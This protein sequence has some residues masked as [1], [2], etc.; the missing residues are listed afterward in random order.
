MTID[1]AQ[2]TLAPTWRAVEYLR[3]STDYQQIS[4]STQQDRIR[5]YALIHGLEVVRTYMDDGR[6]GLNLERRA[7]LRALLA[8]VFRR[9][10]AF[11]V[12]LVYDIS[13]WGR[14]Q[15]IDE[16][17]HYEFLCRQAGK[18]FTYCAELLGDA[19]SL[20]SGLF[21]GVKRLMA[22][23]YS[24]DLSRKVLAGQLRLASMGYHVSGSSPYG[25]RRQLITAHG[26]VRQLMQRGDRKAVIDE[27]VVLVPGPRDEVQQVRTIF[28]WFAHERASLTSI[29]QRLRVGQVP[30]P[31]HVPR[32]TTVV[33]RAM[34]LN[35]RYIG[36]ML[37]NKSTSSLSTHTVPTP[38]E[39]WVRVPDA[40]PA[41]FDRTLFDSAQAR[42]QADPRC[43]NQASLVERLGTLYAMHGKLSSSILATSPGAPCTTTLHK[44]FG[45]LEN[46]FR[47]AGF[48]PYQS[49]LGGAGE[50]LATRQRMKET[51][52]PL[53]T[54][55]ASNGLSVQQGTRR[56]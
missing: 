8:A 50:R 21:K 22:A 47:E 11:D 26:Q 6:S 28:E 36:T 55:L 2:T 17:A 23:E 7:G 27:R 34:L 3:R 35:E 38:V 9:D 49:N 16:S 13:R 39:A 56:P 40:F 41:L 20:L 24:R 53:K 54:L 1:R 14:F 18:P 5:Q 33:V 48:D 29:V 12:I 37:F 51:V 43:A 46:A 52:T 45:S 25:L 44:Y 42:L 32:W 15:D 19:S 10:T 31:Q 30:L 4:L